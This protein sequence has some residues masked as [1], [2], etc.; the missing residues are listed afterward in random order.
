MAH[1]SIE[2][3]GS[4]IIQFRHPNGKRHTLRLGKVA[5]RLAEGVLFRVNEILA[6]IK[7]SQAISADTAAWLGGLTPSLHDRFARVGLATPR[8]DAA[9]KEVT[10]DAFVCEYI[11][12]RAKLRPNTIRNLQQSRRIVAKHF[13]KDRKIAGIGLGDADAYREALIASYS[14]VTVAREVKRARQFFKAAVRRGLIASNPFA[15]VKG[16]SQVNSAKNFFVTR[17]TAAAVLDACPDNE[18]RLIFSLSRF[19]GL[20]CPSETL[21]LRWQD[22]NWDRDR[23]LIRGGKTKQRIIP[24]FDEIRPFLE[25]AFEEAGE[26]AV[27]V[28]ARYRSDNTNLRTQLLRILDNASITVWPRPFHNLRASRE[29]ELA[30]EFPIHVVCEWIGNSE[31]VARKH[32]LQVTEAHF[33]KATSNPTS[34]VR[35]DGGKRRQTEKET[36]VSPAIAKNTAVLVP[37]RGVE[38]RFSG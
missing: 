5:K 36:A 12:G 3:N 24:L 4:S 17:E 29:T 14:P 38:P 37:P 23:I 33:Q 31:E 6:A 28:I 10:L 32:Y 2:K 15:D 21:Q 7:T 34:H 18:W 22:I 8:A 35:A 26:G 30:N 16:G 9:A 13:G 25:R 20:R 19:G 1:I 11:E 27:Y